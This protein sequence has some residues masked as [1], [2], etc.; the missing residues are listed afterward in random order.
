MRAAVDEFVSAHNKTRMAALRFNRTAQL[1]IDP[2]AQEFW[3]QVDTSL[4]GTGAMDTV[5]AVVK[6]ADENVSLAATRSV[7][8]FDSRGIA[9]SAG[10]CQAANFQVVFSRGLYADT[11]TST[12]TGLMTR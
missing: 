1:T 8:C 9:T 2:T 10:S 7:I 11:L 12:A 6:L 3:V 5:G 4:T